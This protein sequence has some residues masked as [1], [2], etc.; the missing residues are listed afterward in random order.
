MPATKHLICVLYEMPSGKNWIIPKI[1]DSK[2]SEKQ[3]D[4]AD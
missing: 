2:Y 3:D 4:G 1:W